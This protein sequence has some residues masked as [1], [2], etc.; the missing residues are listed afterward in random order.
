MDQ[1][2]REWLVLIALGGLFTT[3]VLLP[4]VPAVLIYRLF[5]DNVVTA[6]GPFAGLTVKTSGAFA[7]YLIV[8]AATY[9]AIVPK[10]TDIISS[11][12]H[13]FWIVKG[14]IKLV[15]AD[16]S[17]YLHPE[18]LLKNLRVVTPQAY[19]F[20]SYQATLRLEEN[21][22][23]LP[24]VTIEIP[25]FGERAIPLRSMSTKVKIN[26]FSKTIELKEPIVIEEVSSGGT[27]PPATAPRS[28]ES[29]DRPR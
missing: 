4:L 5:P 19:T 2:A 16:G 17:D 18:A 23:G 13:Q 1:I 14:D 7:A 26:Y 3:W 6:S 20:E 12:R 29:S 8:F 24:T 27:S 22:G 21:E 10:S 15:H 28:A 25:N 11:L 9:F